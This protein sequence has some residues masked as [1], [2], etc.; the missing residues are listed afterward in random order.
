[1]MD[2]LGLVLVVC[3]GASQIEGYHTRNIGELFDGLDDDGKNGGK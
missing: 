2:I 3:I 1:M